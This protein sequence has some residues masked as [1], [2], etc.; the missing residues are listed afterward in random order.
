[1][2]NV[3]IEIKAPEIA[4]AIRL[5]ATS[6]HVTGLSAVDAQSNQHVGIPAPAPAVAPSQAPA[7]QTFAPAPQMP[8]AAPEAAPLAAVPTAAQTYTAEQL[9]VAATQLMDAGRRAELVSLLASFG[10]QALTQLPKE[11]Y[12]AF[13]TQLRAMGARL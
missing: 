12:G 13:A 9:A 10:V 3:M 11:H 2:F 1:M 7:P 8:A 6:L 4:E 5:L